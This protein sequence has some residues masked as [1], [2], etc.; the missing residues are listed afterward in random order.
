[1][2]VCLEQAAGSDVDDSEGEARR[3]SGSCEELDVRYAMPL[4]GQHDNRLAVH[5]RH[6]LRLDA[7]TARPRTGDLAMR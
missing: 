4:P 5:G 7:E 3:V 6:P 1:M 2:H